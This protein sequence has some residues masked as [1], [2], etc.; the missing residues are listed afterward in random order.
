M[1]VTVDD[2][3]SR[4]AASGGS[5]DVKARGPMTTDGDILGGTSSIFLSSDAVGIA[6]VSIVP[7][8]GGVTTNVMQV[9]FTG[10]FGSYDYTVFASA[11]GTYSDYATYTGFVVK[12]SKTGT[13]VKIR[14]QLAGYADLTHE[15][16]HIDFIVF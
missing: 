6:G 5:S 2:R 14:F 16:L 10:D 8:P 12:G 1:R 11:W 9:N 15:I 13:S 4:P 3:N 7:D